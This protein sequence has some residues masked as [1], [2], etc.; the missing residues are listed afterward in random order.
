MTVTTDPV[1]LNQWVPCAWDGQIPVGGSLDTMIFGQPI[2]VQRTGEDSYRVAA[3]D[4][5]TERELPVQVR[6]TCVFTTLGDTPRPLPEIAEF[7]E[8]DRRITG[9]GNVGVNTS[10]YRLVENFLDMAHFAFIHTDVLGALDQTEVLAYRTE[11]RKEVD[12]IW[13]IDC[14][15]YQP[16]ASKAATGGQLTRYVYRVMSPFSVMLYKNVVTDPSRN[17]AICVFIQP[18]RETEC[19]AYMPMAI[20]DEVSTV[21]DLIDFQQSIFLQDRV[22]LENQRPALLPLDPTSE[23]PTRADASSIAYRRWLKAMDIRF[24]IL[25]KQAA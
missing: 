6:Y 4:G 9:C 1:A 19:L 15:F 7:D 25:E 5:T 3:V 22:I 23:L 10:P 8:A 14:T 12:E 24:G 13:A 18:K 16:A 20:V 2:H 11:H 17:D 21:G